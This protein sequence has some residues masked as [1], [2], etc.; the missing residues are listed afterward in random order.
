MAVVSGLANPGASGDPQPGLS[1]NQRAILEFIALADGEGST[2]AHDIAV[3]IGVPPRSMGFRLRRLEQ[4]RLID[5][6]VY[7]KRAS[8]RSDRLHGWVLT[9]RGREAIS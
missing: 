3:E 5:R 1:D 2:L 6:I 9:D 7:R 4:M 8:R